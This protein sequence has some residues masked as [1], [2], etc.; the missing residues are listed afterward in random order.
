MKT[1]SIV[2]ASLVGTLHGAETWQSATTNQPGREYPRVD[3]KGRVQARVEAP[4]ATSVM[5]DIGA[6]KYPLAKGADGAW[7]GNSKPQDE[8]FHYYQLNIDGANVP[9]PNSRSF[10]GASRWGSGI[11]IPAK[12]EDFY[13][14]KN[15]PHGELRE[16]Y[17]FSATSK[18]TRHIFVYTPPGYGRDPGKRYPVLY[19]QHGGGENE[20]GWGS[21]GHT[22]HIMDNLIA[23]GKAKPFLIVMENGHDTGKAELP[24]APEGESDNDSRHR[25]FFGHFEIFGNVVINDLIPF[26]DAN[27]L[28]RPEQAHRAM[29]GLSMGG[30][31]TRGIAL[32][33]PDV[34]S[35]IGV[36]SGG[37]IKTAEIKDLEA[38]KAKV[39]LVFFSFGSKEQP[40]A[41]T[42]KADADALKAAGVNSHYY[43][44]NGTAHEWQSWRRSLHRFAQ[45]VFQD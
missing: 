39:K 31:Q 40:G 29:A 5:L 12:D 32:K 4:G 23:D 20:T 19:L 1:L 9:D 45:L 11:E 6:V 17:Y 24:K 28:T 38:F 30:M 13:A 37:S 2:I 18:S 36:F 25:R 42:A 43:E 27:Y 3:E 35:A 16:T 26:I 8:G 34:F 21:Q 10:Y 14:L 44:S 22:A 15:V 7:I 33:H 41:Q